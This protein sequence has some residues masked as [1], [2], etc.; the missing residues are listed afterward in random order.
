MQGDDEVGCGNIRVNPCNPWLTCV[1]GRYDYSA[2]M[3][4]E[5]LTGAIV[6]A[7]MAVSNELKP[8][9]DERVYE[10]ALVIELTHRGHTIEQQVRHPVHYRGECVG[11]FVPDLVVD[12]LVIVETKVV[13]CFTQTHFAQ[14]LG[15]LT[16]TGL[17]VGLLL[18]FK[19]ASLA[20]KRVVRD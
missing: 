18:N 8:G 13:S 7:A 4:Y 5:Q 9:L 10:R 20:W 16:I 17:H 11:V 3:K 2:L 1:H 19:E 14:M 12:A 15:Y 6:G